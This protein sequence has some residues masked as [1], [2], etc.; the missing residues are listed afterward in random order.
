MKKLKT[1]L[2]ILVAIMGITFTAYGIHLEHIPGDIDRD[3]EVTI[4]DLVIVNRA[5]L[6]KYV[7]AYDY[8]RVDMNGDGVIDQL[9][10]EAISDILL[11]K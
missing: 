7:G 4:T 10:V 11:H 2:I 3:H 1:L 9:D 6:G 8:S 5:A